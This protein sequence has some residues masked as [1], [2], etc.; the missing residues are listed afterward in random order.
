VSLIGSLEDVSF[1]DILQ[2]IH[3]SRQTG[4]L[5]LKDGMEERRVR[6]RGGLVCGATLGEGGPELED[7]LVRKGLI[8]PAALESARA[9]AAQRGE[10]L[11]TALIALGGVSRETVERV[12]R[13]EIRSTL[14]HLILLQEGEF[15]FDLD[16]NAGP[17]PEEIRLQDG[18]APDS[19]LEG[20][21]SPQPFAAVER[22]NAG[23]EPPR[24]PSSRL[25][26]VTDRTGL[27]GI[28]RDEL[29]RR[30]FEVIEASGTGAAMDEARSMLGRGETFAL[31]CDLILPDGRD[32][33]GRG[34]LDLV[35][36]MRNLFPDLQAVIFGELRESGPALATG[37]V[38]ALAF[39]PL[40]ET[41]GA[42]TPADRAALSRFCAI[43]RATLRWGEDTASAAGHGGAE[44]IRVA[45]SLSLLRG[46]ICEMQN[47]G[48]SEIPLLILRLAA[49]HFERGVLFSI[50]EAGACCTGAFG[51]D[52]SG[53]GGLEARV[54]GVVLELPESSA[55]HDV[56]RRGRAAIGRIEAIPA[57]Q[58][59]VETLGAPIAEEAA[60]LPVTSGREVVG[61]LYGDN[62]ASRRPI[63]DLQGLEIFL[64]Q[65]GIA[66]QNALLKRRIASIG[67][68]S[69][70]A[71]RRIRA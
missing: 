37:S 50:G 48:E 28:L 24:R 39:L 60:I 43:A 30:G 69:G 68:A 17:A 19:I 45:D 25:L 33:P 59:L 7:L 35:R 4:T 8:G 15:R 36:E 67:A 58:P 63:G 21:A 27:R 23:S 3:L 34:G 49:E 70:A 18:L 11:A 65:A 5:V 54:R 22:W 38:G 64:S 16:S 32:H 2:V 53:S 42:A 6:F 10:P 55:L 40:P 20:L 13:D 52:T 47:E 29:T 41:S 26:L 56:V 12:V 57:N 14:R 1:P 51:P 61:V 66:L 9:R 44:A 71:A 31:L 62:A 46:L